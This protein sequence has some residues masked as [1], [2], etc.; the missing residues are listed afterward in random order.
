[1]DIY[2][3]TARSSS[4]IEPSP[5]SRDCPPSDFNAD[6][7]PI[8]ARHWFGVVLD[9]PIAERIVQRLAAIRELRDAA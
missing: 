3:S 1:M 4:R 7:Y 5:F 6:M 2:A 9:S 8:L